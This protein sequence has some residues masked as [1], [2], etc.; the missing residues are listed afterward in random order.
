MTLE[1]LPYVRY[2]AR[3]VGN[4]D[5]VAAKVILSTAYLLVTYP[6]AAP[7]PPAA[8]REALEGL[9]R[10][11]G[12]RI[13]TPGD[14]PLD[15]PADLNWELPSAGKRGKA[16]VPMQP[17]AGKTGLSNPPWFEDDKA[18]FSTDSFAY[19]L[20]KKFADR[21]PISGE[22]T[23][24]KIM[25]VTDKH[26]PLT[27]RIQRLTNKGCVGQWR[28]PFYIRDIALNHWLYLEYMKEPGAALPT[29]LASVSLQQLHF[30]P[31]SKASK[32]KA[33][34]PPD[35]SS[36]KSASSKQGTL[37]AWKRPAPSVPPITVL[38]T[39]EVEE[40]RA[41][42]LAILTA[43]ASPPTGEWFEEE[44]RAFRLEDFNYLVGLQLSDV[45]RRTGATEVW[46]VKDIRVVSNCLVARRQRVENRRTHGPWLGPFH[47]R[48]IAV[49]HWLSSVRGEASLAFAPQ[50]V[51]LKRL[52]KDPF[53]CPGGTGS[54]GAAGDWHQTAERVGSESARV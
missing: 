40:D 48:D 27:A 25:E 6:R 38:R 35:Q 1:P 18:V 47:V 42:P 5:I 30:G 39:G 53:S 9:L 52:G 7:A 49:N 29:V 41:A 21:C 28:G 33:Q 2:W 17:M 20:K 13:P 26:G 34:S 51:D 4:L 50:E 43:P 24:W 15:F 23:E 46:V 14:R 44:G 10:D 54:I 37:E 12:A 36:P 31:T 45:N 16:S 22:V 3:A 8:Y 32:R 11:L 19:L